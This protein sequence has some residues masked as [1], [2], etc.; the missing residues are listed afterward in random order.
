MCIYVCMY[1]YIYIHI[2]II[3]Y[4]HTMHAYVRRSRGGTAF[5]PG[6]WIGVELD[7]EG[8]V[9]NGAREGLLL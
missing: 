7:A 8:G 1:I 3:T 2:H 6:E 9:H 5:A 4:T